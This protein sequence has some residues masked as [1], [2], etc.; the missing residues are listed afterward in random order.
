MLLPIMFFNNSITLTQDLGKR[1]PV[2]SDDK[3]ANLNG[4]IVGKGGHTPP[5]LDQPLSRNSRCPHLS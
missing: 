2:P 3:Q 5:F 4:P 1:L